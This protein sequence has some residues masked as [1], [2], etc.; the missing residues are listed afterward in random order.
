M[1]PSLRFGFALLRSLSQ[2]AAVTRGA[3]EAGGRGVSTHGSSGAFSPWQQRVRSS[4]FPAGCGKAWTRSKEG[5]T[6]GSVLQ[7][8]RKPDYNFFES[9]KS[10]RSVHPEQPFYILNPKMPWQLWDILQENSLEHIQPNP[11]S[12]GMLGKRIAL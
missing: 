4:L 9:Y 10:Y 2:V 7:W 12:S 1:A 11:P 6:S 8:Y 3:G 5:L